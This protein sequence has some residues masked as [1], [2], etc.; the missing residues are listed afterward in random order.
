MHVRYRKAASKNLLAMAAIVAVDTALPG[1]AYAQMALEEV[2]V[3]ARKR[4][5]TLQDTPIAVSAFNND[6]LRA[7]QID[8]VGDLT[9]NVPGLSRREGRKTADLNIRGVGTRVSGV[10][11]E[12][13]VGVYVDSIY[14]ARNDAQLV[15]VLNMESVQVL[16]GPQGTLFGKN[17]AGGA[18]LLTTKKP[19]DEFQGFASANVGDLGRTNLRGGVSGPLYEDGLFGGIQ[20]DYQDE[21]GYRKDAVT[22]EGYGN[23]DRYS[24]LGQMR[25]E[26][27]EIFVG[28]LMLFYGEVDENTF[29]AN[30]IQSNPAAALQRFTAPGNATPYA[31]LCQQS[32]DLV[33]NEKVIFDHTPLRYKITNYL[34]GLTL[35]WDLEPFTVKS[36]SG[37]LYQENIDT[38]SNDIDAT[39]LLT[40]GNQWEPGRQLNA[41]GIDADDESRT[42]V[43]QEFQLLGD[44]FDDFVT[45]TLGAFYSYEKIDDSPF[46]QMLGPGGFLGT[47]R[48]DGSVSLLPTSVS[49]REATLREFENTSAAIFGQGILSLSDMW[50]LTLGG[51]YTYEE[52]KAEQTNYIAAEQF[53][54]GNVVSRE[55]FN[56]L[57]NYIHQ[58]I[59]DPEN[60]NPGDDDNWTQF[61]PSVTLTMFTPDAWR[62]DLFD[63]GMMYASASGGFKAGGFSPFGAEFLAFDPEN[64][65]TYELGYKLELWDQ[66]ARLNGAFYYSEYDDIQIT[67]TRTFPREDPSLPPVTQNGT[68]N[69]GKATI[70]GAE[71]E[72]TIMPVDGL[73]FAATASYIDARY[74][75][76]M[77][78]AP[79]ADGSVQPIDR[80]HEDFAYTP[81]HTY[82]ATAQYDWVTGIGSIV[83]RLHYYYTSSQFIGLDAGAAAANEAYLDSYDVWKF[84][85]AFQ[86]DY[87]QGLEIAGYVDNFTDEEYF[88]TGI[89]SIS[90]VGSVALVPG[91]QRTYGVEVYYSW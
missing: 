20:V 55:E 50:Q 91:K 9:R 66:R 8:N 46:G 36:I 49:F 13:G 33:D 35:A 71:L 23:V 7:A 4:E 76:F 69:A 44:A 32:T 57:A 26:T 51:R 83:P 73:L 88:G 29:P 58:V 67:V 70:R 74:D 85:L 84:R 41:N 27:D 10:A 82:T 89:A 59:P 54:V 62:G 81:E 12:A 77:D 53:P 45:Y 52:K 21:D 78:I 48:A 16:R 2:V 39:D 15:D 86:P 5:E 56:A 38:V 64:L 42:F 40:L 34:S 68:D 19:G 90:G 87:V 30:C 75:E 79:Q 25:Y 72:F 24:I 1:P 43:S 37:Y 14:I 63:G 28:D 60:P 18:I 65:W 6:T 3:T 80:S 17:T 22:G 61:T 11:A 47:T 31:E